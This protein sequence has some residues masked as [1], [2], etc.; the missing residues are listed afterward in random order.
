MQPTQRLRFHFVEHTVRLIWHDNNASKA[1]LAGVQQ[2]LGRD[3]TPAE[4]SDVTD[5]VQRFC[6]EAD[7]LLRSR[8]PHQT[9]SRNASVELWGYQQ[10][11]ALHPDIHQQQPTAED[12]A[13]QFQ[14]PAGEIWPWNIVYTFTGPYY[15][16]QADATGQAATRSVELGSLA[17]VLKMAAILKTF[18]GCE[19]LGDLTPDNIMNFTLEA[20]ECRKMSAVLQHQQAAV[21]RALSQML[22]G[23]NTP[24]HAMELMQL[25]QAPLQAAQQQGIAQFRRGKP[26]E[27]IEVA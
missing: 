4:A 22:Q 8:I 27:S 19:V 11:Q 15:G 16:I 24:Q 23:D 2:D 18:D 26:I 12:V 21:A 7:T 3:L 9:P 5:Q 13:H 25:W 17:F 1:V 14:L 20:D 10:I 6:A